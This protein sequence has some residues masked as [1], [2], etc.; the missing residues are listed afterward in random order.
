MLEPLK[1]HTKLKQKEINELKAL[2][3]KYKEHSIILEHLL[4][5]EIEEKS[6]KIKEI[7]IE[8]KE[9]TYLKKKA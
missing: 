7:T 8:M 9:K 3:V 1:V 4:Q 2:I 5:A 6:T